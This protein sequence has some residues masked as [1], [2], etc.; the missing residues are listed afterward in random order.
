MND[1]QERLKQQQH[2]QELAT[3]LGLETPSSAAGPPAPKETEKP[4]WNP[5]AAEPPAAEPPAPEPAFPSEPAFATMDRVPPAVLEVRPV[6]LPEE[7]TE[8]G[9]RRRGRRGRKFRDDDQES[10]GPA[11]ERAV[12]EA[13]DV[14]TEPP[15]PKE[16]EPGGQRGRRRSKLRPPPEPVADVK[17]DG[18]EEE[19][20]PKPEDNED[21]DAELNVV[22][23]DWNMPSWTELI[24]SLYRPDR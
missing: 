8:H 24:D 17:E 15:L 6:P 2:W 18:P 13:P 19:S 22:V 5:P 7:E 11:Q 3:L 23:A 21:L 16:E 14:K 20:A 4:R 12:D 10:A 9:Q 1:E